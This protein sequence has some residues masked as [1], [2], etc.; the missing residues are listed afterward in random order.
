MIGS[1]RLFQIFLVAIELRWSNSFEPSTFLLRTVGH[2]LQANAATSTRRYILQDYNSAGLETSFEDDDEN[3]DQWLNARLAAIRNMSRKELE[4]ELYHNDIDCRGSHEELVC[5]LLK[6]RLEASHDISP[7]PPEYLEPARHTHTTSEPSIKPVYRHDEIPMILEEPTI[8]SFEDVSFLEADMEQDLTPD[9][10]WS[11]TNNRKAAISLDAY[12]DSRRRQHFER[13]KEWFNDRKSSYPGNQNQFVIDDED[14]GGTASFSNT[15]RTSFPEEYTVRPGQQGDLFEHPHYP[16]SHFY[17][18][19]EVTRQPSQKQPRDLYRP[20]THAKT[21]AH[22]T[23]QGRA[24]YKLDD[25]TRAKVH[26]EHSCIELPMSM[27]HGVPVVS[28]HMQRNGSFESAPTEFVIDTARHTS[29]ISGGNMQ[30]LHLA[31]SSDASNGVISKLKPVLDDK[32]TR[33][34]LSSGDVD[35]DS[36]SIKLSSGKTDPSEPL[37]TTNGTPANKS[38]NNMVDKSMSVDGFWTSNGVFFDAPVEMEVLEQ[39]EKI[40]PS[41]HGFLGMDVLCTFDSVEFDFDHDV[42]RLYTGD[43]PN[44]QFVMTEAALQPLSLNAELPD[45]YTLPLRVDGKGPANMLISTALSS[46]VM[47]WKGVNESLGLSR[48]SNE[49]SD[50]EST[51]SPHSTVA[52]HFT[53]HLSVSRKLDLGTGKRLIRMSDPILDTSSSL[54]GLPH[55]AGLNIPVGQFP[56]NI[57]QNEVLNQAFERKRTGGIIG[58]DVLSRCSV[59]RLAMDRSMEVQMFSRRLDYGNVVLRP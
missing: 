30:H 16:D 17:D 39:E 18:E 48:H 1:V 7:P 9:Q 3:M 29:A 38:S 26:R 51:F 46:T 56:T 28:L 34:L 42:L 49:I 21:K 12:D 22:Q 8:S 59:L 23:S 58:M 32:E 15:G 6:A 52:S 55:M 14:L 19:F 47:T 40:L 31:M 37:S 36:S 5:R 20:T 33:F 10:H 4:W 11:T 43:S 41:H 45:L 50:I 53:H 54:P 44:L 13:H 25:K 2:P 27:H 35:D 57:G 24:L